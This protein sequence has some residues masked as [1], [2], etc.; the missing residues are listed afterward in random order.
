MKMQVKRGEIYTIN[1]IERGTA[2]IEMAK[3]RPG[4]V[5]QGDL[6]NQ[7]L[8]STIILPLSSSQPHYVGP[9]TVVLHPGES[10]L[11]KPSTVVFT[12]I[13]AIDQS[14]LEKRIGTTPKSEMNE[15][16]QVLPLVLG[17]ESL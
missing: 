7:E 17:L 1:L 16:D 14:R 6:Y 15:I 9:G 8:P 10:G 3:K 2:G 11:T 13:R 5:I 4:I 12:Q